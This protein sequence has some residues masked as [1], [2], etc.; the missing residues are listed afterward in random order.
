MQVFGVN[1]CSMAAFLPFLSVF[2]S[3]PGLSTIDINLVH[4]LWT[5]RNETKAK[6]PFMVPFNQ[7]NA[8]KNSVL[9]PLLGI[10]FYEFAARLLNHIPSMDCVVK[11]VRWHGYSLCRIPAV[12]VL[13]ASRRCRTYSTR[14]CM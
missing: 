13:L 14:G 2:G 10:S 12:S 5:L 3:D 4:P 1:V 8:F 9:F 7:L 6:L 11:Y